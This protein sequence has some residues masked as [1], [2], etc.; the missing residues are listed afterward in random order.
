MSI[1]R[2]RFIGSLVLLVGGSGRSGSVIAQGDVFPSRTVKLVVPFPPGGSNDVVGRAVA[3]KL[4]T[5]WGQ[6]VIV[7]NRSGAGGNLGAAQVARAPADGYTLLVVANNFV[8]NPTLYAEG[9]AGYDPVRDFKPISLLARV[10]ILL[11]VNPQLPVQT[12]GELIALAK[13]K[14]GQLSY[15][16]AGIGTPHHLSAELFKRL[17]GIEMTHVPYRG[18]VPAATDL[19]SG[20]VQVLFGVANS[21]LPLVKKGLL[22]PL[23][24]CGETR[25]ADLPQV[26]RVA[27]TRGLESFQ[28]EV[29]IGLVAPAA[30]SD[31]LRERLHRDIVGALA[32]PA[33]RKTLA[34]QDLTVESSSPQR[35]ASVMADDM[36]RWARVIRDTGARAE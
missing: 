7:D 20:Q 29:W 12:V 4:S 2:R 30:L 14:P 8:I 21:V 11:L 27:E 24:V 28:S 9:K 33:L 22:R 32:D 23:G 10:P 13:S 25:L 6:P 18:A 17:A 26:P 1:Q 35:L 31:S 3:Q 34:S 16:S 15:A 19:I 5:Q 36:A